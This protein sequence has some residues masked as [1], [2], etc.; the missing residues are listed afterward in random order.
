MK[1]PNPPKLLILSADWDIITKALESDPATA[2]SLAQH[3][4]R[5]RN[6]NWR[7]SSV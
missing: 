4:C 7:R 5:N 6:V 2:N 3:P 1:R